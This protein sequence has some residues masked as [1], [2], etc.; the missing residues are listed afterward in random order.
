MNFPY[1]IPPPAA[2]STTWR[3]FEICIT[4]FMITIIAMLGYI[5]YQVSWM[6][7]VLQNQKIQ[8]TY[9]VGQ[10]VALGAI[11]QELRCESKVLHR[12]SAICEGNTT[13]VCHSDTTEE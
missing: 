2:Q 9:L 12:L 7:N 1:N 8:S 13:T 4:F 11:S 3:T 6:D 10:N 5:T